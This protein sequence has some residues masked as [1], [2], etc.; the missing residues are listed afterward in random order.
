MIR[1]AR[2]EE[3]WLGQSFGEGEAERRTDRWML[4]RRRL[5][6][7]VQ[8]GALGGRLEVGGC[9]CRRVCVCVYVLYWM[10]MNE[11]DLSIGS[12]QSQSVPVPVLVE[13][14]SDPVFD[15]PCLGW[16]VIHA[17]SCL[18]ACSLPAL[19]RLTVRRHAGHGC[20][21]RACSQF[22]YGCAADC[23]TYVSISLP[24][25]SCFRLQV[26]V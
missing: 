22:S 6:R 15:L 18:S 17:P 26:S 14:S 21:A 1:K 20:Q 5:Q 16:A 13:S 9:A 10:M 24:V 7:G 8:F 19:E 25:P 23:S 3:C 2:Q 4:D 12:S 11:Y